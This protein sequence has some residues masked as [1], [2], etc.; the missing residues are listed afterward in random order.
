MKI[1]IELYKRL[2]MEDLNNEFVKACAFGQLELIKFLL[3]SPEL[4]LH[5]Y[6]RLNNNNPLKWACK[7]NQVETIKY[8]VSSPELKRHADIHANSEYAFRE[9]LNHNSEELLHFYIFYLRIEKNSMIDGILNEHNLMDI[10][11]KAESMFQFR[12]LN[13]TLLINK[14]EKNKPKL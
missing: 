14:K 12:E 3:L 7:N 8:L 1:D 9:A 4:Q 2:G 5:P 13:Q 10:T 11:K 6:I